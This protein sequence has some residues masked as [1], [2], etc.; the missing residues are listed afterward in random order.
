MGT[1]AVRMSKSSSDRGTPR[2]PAIASRCTTALVE[3]P[4]AAFT[5]TAFSNACLV[6]TEDNRW[7]CS[8]MATIRRPA[9]C[10]SAYR[11]ESTA[12]TAAAPGSCTPRAS[13]TQAIVEA[14]PIV[15]QWP[16]LRDM[17]TSAS[18]QSAAVIRPARISSV[19]RQ[20]TVPEPMSWPRNLPLSIGPPVIIR[21]GRSTLAA[22]ISRP[23]VVLS[24]PESRTTPS[25]G[26]A[27]T[28]S[29]NSIASRLR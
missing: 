19:K 4:I 2:R 6:S 9:A 10:A 18:E 26:L 27:R 13:V 3:P 21:V 12:G 17:P 1:S 24:Q 8:T 11:R 14:V 20:T 22:P 23:G 29:S 15:M 7:S 28:D 25:S 5:R 16:R